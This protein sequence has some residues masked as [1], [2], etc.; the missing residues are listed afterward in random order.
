MRHFHRPWT[1]A[2]MLVVVGTTLAAQRGAPPTNLSKPTLLPPNPRLEALKKDVIAD[3][4][5]RRQLTQQMVD[6]LFSFSELG[7]QEFETQRYVTGLLEKE[8]FT[9]QRGVADIPTSW[10]GELGIGPAGDRARDRHRRRPGSEPDAGVVT[11]EQLVPGAPGH[12]EGHNS[13]QAVMVT[14]VARRQAIMEREKLPGTLCS[15]PASP[16]SSSRPRRTWCEQASSRM[17]TPCSTRTSAAALGHD[18]GR[19]QQQR[20]RLGRVHL[21]GLDLTR[22][23]RAMARPQRAGRRRA[24]EHRLELQARAPPALAAIALRHHERRRPAERRARRA[25]PSGTTSARTTTTASKNCGTSATR[26]PRARR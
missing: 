18:V 20:A 9:V 16:R 11:R 4:E 7:F 13:G 15:G 22:R 12:G 1:L 19:H 14:A 10:V 6:S 3:V 8:G 5:K 23:D 24:D 26:W 25:R 17:W 2:L 21:H